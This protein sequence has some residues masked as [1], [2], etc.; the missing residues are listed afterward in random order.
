VAAAAWALGKVSSPTASQDK[1]AS[2]ISQTSPVAPSPVTSETTTESA[3]V[4]ASAPP[5]T[6]GTVEI[7]PTASAL[8]TTQKT[9]KPTLKDLKRDD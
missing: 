6:S 8:A 3:V 2:S 7:K 9:A 1:A 4:S 5:V